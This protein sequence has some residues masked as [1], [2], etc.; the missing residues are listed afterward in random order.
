MSH[1]DVFDNHAPLFQLICVPLLA[2]PYLNAVLTW[3]GRRSNFAGASHRRRHFRSPDPCGRAARDIGSTA[4]AR[5]RIHRAQVVAISPQ[6]G[7]IRVAGQRLG[8]THV[9]VSVASNVRAP[10]DYA[11]IAPDGSAT[12]ILDGA[13][14]SGARGL[15]GGRPP[16]VSSAESRLA[17]VW[18]P[19]LQR[20]L[21]R[22]ELFP[23][24]DR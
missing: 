15:F 22:G 12:G 10:V 4:R 1:R 6:S 13:E 9:G 20:G 14:L 23:A 7:L 18:V 24:I 3:R 11:L 16:F 5:R 8:L 19:A 21:Q 2:E 17:V